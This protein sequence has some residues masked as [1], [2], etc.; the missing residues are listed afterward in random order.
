M[1]STLPALRF[2]AALHKYIVK[3]TAKYTLMH[4]TAMEVRLGAHPVQI[5]G[6][7]LAGS[8]RVLQ[9]EKAGEG[10]AVVGDLKPAQLC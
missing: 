1:A 5:Q 3:I 9:Q 2:Q 10:R 8:D 7:R 6:A 4:V